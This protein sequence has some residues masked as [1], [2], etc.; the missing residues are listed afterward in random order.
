M[1][2]N[3]LNRQF[4]ADRVN[5][6]WCGDITY[7]RLRDG[8][9]VS[10][11]VVLDLYS[12]RVIGWSVAD[13]LHTALVTEAQQQALWQRRPSAGGVVMHTDQ[14]CQYQS[15]EFRRLL[16]SW[17]VAQSLSRRGNCWDNAVAESFF[18]TLEVE[19]LPDLDLSTVEE[20][21]QEIGE[22]IAQVYNRCRLH[23]SLGYCSPVEYENRSLY[24]NPLST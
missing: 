9:F 14:G 12:R 1:A 11:A 2:T 6:K 15:R 19:V 17:G 22:W 5:Q 8:S 23:S 21:R 4:K 3:V 13:T 16:Q 10:L 24:N 20:A 18:A 7:V